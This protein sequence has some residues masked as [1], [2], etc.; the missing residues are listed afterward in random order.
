MKIKNQYGF[1]PIEIIIAIVLVV[2]IGAAGYFAYKADH[3]TASVTNPKITSTTST[4]SSGSSVIATSKDA[5][6][7]FTLSNAQSVMG[8]SAVFSSANSN[9]CRYR[10]TT[11]SGGEATLLVQT[12]NLSAES[13]SRA[14]AWKLLSGNDPNILGLGDQAVFDNGNTLDVRKGNIVVVASYL[15]ENGT[16]NQSIDTQVAK[17][18]LS[19]F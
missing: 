2:G 18:M 16:S 12:V 11:T 17:V 10:S 19:N 14:Y 7:L 15:D 9:G 3:K 4:S 1:T 8:A 13:T 6:Q 5:C